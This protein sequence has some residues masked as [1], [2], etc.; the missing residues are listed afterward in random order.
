MKK[1]DIQQLIERLK[2][3]GIKS[4]ILEKTIRFS[5]LG[6]IDR[7]MDGIINLNAKAHKLKWY[8]QG[9]NFVDNVRNICFDLPAKGV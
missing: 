1:E 3:L 2:G 8:A 4:K 9:F 5:Y 7:S 6:V